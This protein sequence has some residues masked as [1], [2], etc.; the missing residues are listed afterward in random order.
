MDPVAERGDDRA[1]D[2]RWRGELD[3]R[4]AADALQ[5]HRRGGAAQPVCDRRLRLEL[6]RD[7]GEHLSALLA[8]GGD[9]GGAPALRGGG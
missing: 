9:L 1:G 8:R 5:Q 6:G 3:F 2:Q 7:G 4:I